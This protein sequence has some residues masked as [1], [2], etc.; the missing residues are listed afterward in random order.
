MIVVLS[1]NT[2]G[3]FTALVATPTTAA[4][5][6]GQYFGSIVANGKSLTVNNSLTFAGTDSTTMTF[7]GASDTVV[8]L[9]AAQTLTNKPSPVLL[10]RSRI[11][12]THR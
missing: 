11:L 9:A 8:T 1:G 7:P 2:S 10:I 5:W 6:D 4:N 3:L 12:P